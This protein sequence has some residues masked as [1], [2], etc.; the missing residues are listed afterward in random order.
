VLYIPLPT[1]YSLT[2]HEDALR[3]Q[4]AIRQGIDPSRTASSKPSADEHDGKSYTLNADGTINLKMPEDQW[5]LSA[6]LVR[7]RS[8]FFAQQMMYVINN[9]PEAA[10]VNPASVMR[11]FFQTFLQPTTQAWGAVAYLVNFV[12]IVAILVSIY[13]SVSARMRDIAILRALGATRA[14]ILTTICLEAGL[15]GLL[16]ALLGIV[17]GHAL[18]ALASNYL[19]QTIGESLRWWVVA[20]EEWLYLL[21]VTAVAVLAGLVPAFKAYRSPVADNLVAV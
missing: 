17:L 15:I 16:G 8:P 3:A 5:A 1:F 20:P 9:R 11:E 21:G 7:S 18:G 10:A 13:N 4:A 6:I 19:Q 14:R 2:E 12:A